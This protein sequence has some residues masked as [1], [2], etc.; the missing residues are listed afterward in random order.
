MKKTRTIG[1][2]TVLALVVCGVLSVAGSAPAAIQNPETFQTYGVADPW[3]P[4]AGS[5]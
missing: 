5:G 4:P 3:T 2:G 1:M